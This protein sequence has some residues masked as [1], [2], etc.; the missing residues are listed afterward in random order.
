LRAEE[1]KFSAGVVIDPIGIYVDNDNNVSQYIRSNNRLEIV[2]SPTK[3]ID[4]FIKNLLNIYNIDDLYGRADDLYKARYTKL[5][6]L[7]TIVYS[8]LDQYGSY[9][10]FKTFYNV[11]KNQYPENIIK[12]IIEFLTPAKSDAEGGIIFEN[13]ILDDKKYQ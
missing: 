7:K 1:V 8:F 13:D 10:D 4:E 11:V 12:F 2:C 5:T 6:E 9:F 3:I